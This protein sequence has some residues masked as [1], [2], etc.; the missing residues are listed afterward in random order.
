MQ[1][2]VRRAMATASALAIVAGCTTR[3]PEEDSLA[4]LTVGIAAPIIQQSGTPLGINHHR[5]ALTRETLVAVGADGRLSPR[6]L[7]SWNVSADGLTWRL[8][9][10]QGIRFHDGTPVTAEHLAPRLRTGLMAALMK[11]I[12]SVEVEGLDAIVIRLHERWA[13]L[14]EDLGQATAVR[15]VVERDTEGKIIRQ[16]SFGT[17]AYVVAEESAER[18]RLREFP[19][20]Y[21]GNPGIAEIRVQLFPDQ[22]NA[23]SALMRNE[24]D[25]LYEVSRDSLDFVRSESSINV[26][27][28]SRP[29]VYLLGFNSR[30]PQLRSPAVRRAINHAIDRQAFVRLA[31]LDEGEPSAGHVGP[32]HWAFDASV[33]APRHDPREAVKMLAAS[34]LT[35]REAPGRMP[36]RLRIKCLVYEPFKRMALVIQ[37]QLA[38]ADIDLELEVLS[39][40]AY[41]DRITAGDYETF[42]FE[43]TTARTVMWPY[44]FWHSQS[45]LWNHGY[46]GADDVLDRMRTAATDDEMR[47]ATS[48]FQRRLLDDPP[49]AFLA[50]GRVS[51]AVARRFELPPAGI[52][53]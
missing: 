40:Q 43:M 14:P 17:G 48:A 44:L 39:G 12:A 23:W 31:L 30:S 22:R 2:V 21:R 20:H 32:Q 26:A 50:W 19:N 5:D 18:L 10:R 49:A 3:A 9:V 51:R 46:A 8:R 13:F 42:L 15:T 35:V 47:A 36:A 27:T 7:E 37:R 16:Q 41:V 34:G 25:V 1:Q 11:K 29:Y 38:A 52:D 4:S 53:I 33:A 28:F 24:I 6:V 45:P